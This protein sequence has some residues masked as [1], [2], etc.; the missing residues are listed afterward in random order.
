MKQ[1]YK[2][3]FELKHDKGTFFTSVISYSLKSAK[4]TLQ[5]KENCPMRAITYINK[6][7]LKSV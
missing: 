7:L 6:K 5:K 1:L 3:S 2:Y 4:E